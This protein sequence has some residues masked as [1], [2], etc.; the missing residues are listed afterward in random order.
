MLPKRR[1]LGS[2]TFDEFKRRAADALV[3]AHLYDT[4]SQIKRETNTYLKKI[5]LAI[6]SFSPWKYIHHYS[7]IV[8]KY[9]RVRY[10]Q[11]NRGDTENP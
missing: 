9:L 4:F 10:T 8:T 11:I 5:Y 3:K 6:P 2:V 1:T 7:D